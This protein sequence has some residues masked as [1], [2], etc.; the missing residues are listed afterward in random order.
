M[1]ISDRLKQTDEETFTFRIPNDRD[2]K[3]LQLTDLHLGFGFISR[4]K[5]SLR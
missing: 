3:I 1:Y 4:R 5:I 2:F